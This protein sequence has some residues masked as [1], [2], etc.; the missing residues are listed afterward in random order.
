V[1]EDAWT[2]LDAA[3]RDAKR[4]VF[5]ETKRGWKI[6]R[7][8][9]RNSGT[10]AMHLGGKLWRRA[11]WMRRRAG[12]RLHRWEE[13][14]KRFESHRL[15]WTVE[16]EIARV[17]RGSGLI[18]VG[19]WLSEVGYEV[20]YWIPFV[21]WFQAEHRVDPGR[22]IVV[23]R[24]GASAWYRGITPNAVEIFDFMTPEQYARAN[25]ARGA[26]GSGTLKQWTVTSMDRQI[27]DEAARRAG[28]KS[29]RVLH[30]SMLYRL[31][32]QFWLGHRAQAFLDSRTRYR[33][34]EPPAV[35]LE[36]LPSEFVAV[37]LYTAASLPPTDAV[38]RSL[39][40]MVLALADRTPV[41]M[42]DT[43]L[44]F[45][46]H[47]DYDLGGA[48]RIYTVRDALRPA[49][50]LA[51]QTA[52]IARAKGFVGTCGGLAWLA[53]MLGVDTTAVFTEPRFLHGHLQVA[54]RVFQELRGGRFTPLDLSGVD[55]LGLALTARAASGSAVES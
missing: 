21:R 23:T 40:S 33:L 11:D 54:R 34:I 38:Q 43:G 49:D 7:E 1:L 2:T 42:L 47:A 51:V 19:P 41:V 29:V 50:N 15:E 53:P 13:A 3:A 28:V 48:S 46:D 45:D 14:R 52:V 26:E 6:L 24:G 4:S 5:A 32:R 55:R 27:I 12:R 44:A 10:A 36:A 35:A 9:S 37:K 22:L 20:L 30:P 18:V 8:R 31:F 16:R 25:A 39:R 17:A